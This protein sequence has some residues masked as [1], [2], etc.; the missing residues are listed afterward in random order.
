VVGTTYSGQLALLSLTTAEVL[1]LTSRGTV[2]IHSLPATEMLVGYEPT[3]VPSGHLIYLSNGEGTLMALP[4]DARSRR[5]LDAPVPAEDGVRMEEGFGFGHFGVGVNGVLVYAPGRNAYRG[6]LAL[7]DPSGTADTLKQ[8]PRGHYD[9]LRL[10]P[11]GRRLLAAIRAEAGYPYSSQ[12][13]D[14]ATGQTER[15]RA[16][17]GRASRAMAWLPP[18]GSDVIVTRMDPVTWEYEET[19]VQSLL[20]NRERPLTQG[21]MFWLAAHPSGDYVVGGNVDCSPRIIR[22]DGLEEAGGWEPG[23]HYAFSPDGRWLA[24]TS[25]SDGSVHVVPQPYEGRSYAVTGPGFEQPFWSLDGSALLYKGVREYWRVP[26]SPTGGADGGPLVGPRELYARGPFVRVFS[27]SHAL[28]PDGRL[29]V[30]M[31]PPEESTPHL[32]VVTGFLDHLRRVAPVR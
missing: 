32:E 1:A 9:L 25:W 22:I 21:P 28:A 5:V 15:L 24:F 3:Y 7:V 18:H 13:L 8:F 14:L 23:C 20:D 17:E 11:D 27:S 16:P 29:L 31:G 19:V 30:V 4:F 2:P 10:S 12:I 26:F 6:H